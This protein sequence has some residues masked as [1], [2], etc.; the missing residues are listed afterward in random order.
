MFYAIRHDILKSGMAS[1]NASCTPDVV[2]L[3]ALGFNHTSPSEP[4]THKTKRMSP[5]TL[6]DLKYG[7]YTLW[8]RRPQWIEFEY[9]QCMVMV[10]GQQGA[11]F[12]PSAAGEDIAIQAISFRGLESTKT[13][14]RTFCQASPVR[15][16]T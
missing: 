11:S 12:M 15:K 14:L 3:G 2:R 13:P 1:P 8:E 9:V 5:R 16:S 4:R 7:N 6:P 10:M